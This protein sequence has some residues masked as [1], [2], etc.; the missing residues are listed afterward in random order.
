MFLIKDTLEQRQDK[1]RSFLPVEPVIAVLLAAADLEWTL[2][3]AIR[4]FAHKTGNDP[5]P[6]FEKASGLGTYRECWAKAASPLFAR[7]EEVVRD[8]N[9][10]L[11]S[12]DLRHKLIHGAQGTTGASF[13][14]IRVEAIL[15]A[16]A[17]VAKYAI[18]QGEPIYGKKLPPR[19]KPR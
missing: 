6:K 10:L 11:T 16:S 17:A 19:K 13:A 14:K 8:W 4:R 12:F 2:R 1:I 5:G 18:D 9:S 15:A 3:R 7:L